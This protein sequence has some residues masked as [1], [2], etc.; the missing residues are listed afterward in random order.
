[1]ASTKLSTNRHQA[2][3]SAAKLTT[4][5]IRSTWDRC[6]LTKPCTKPGQ[7][8]PSGCQKLANP[9][10]TSTTIAATSPKA[11]FPQA[12]MR[13]QRQKLTPANNPNGPNHSTAPRS[14]RCLAIETASS[15]CGETKQAETKLSNKPRAAI[16]SSPASKLRQAPSTRPKTAPSKQQNC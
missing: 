3:E 8:T 13:W 15:S 14:K 5:P 6:T 1:M 4:L 10:K 16:H 7:L 11:K 2:V 9:S 12:L